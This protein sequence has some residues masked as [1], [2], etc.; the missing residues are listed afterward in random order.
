M[1]HKNDFIGRDIFVWESA[2]STTLESDIGQKLINNVEKNINMHLF[3][4]KY[5]QIDGVIEPYIYMGMADT[6]YYEGE[7]PITVHLKLRNKV[8][9]KIY[10]ELK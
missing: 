10:N 9:M 3:V 8:A 1:K 7:K 4:R 2:S 5:R 6:V